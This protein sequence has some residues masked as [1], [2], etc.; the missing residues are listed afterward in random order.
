MGLGLGLGLGLRLRL[1]L[2][3]GSGLGRADLLCGAFYRAGWLLYR[4][5]REG[6]AW[7]QRLRT[8]RPERERIEWGS[9]VE[10]ATS[11]NARFQP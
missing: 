8:G 3:L 1:G 4:R 5:T 11:R 2:G 9:Y 6:E 7:R 10:A